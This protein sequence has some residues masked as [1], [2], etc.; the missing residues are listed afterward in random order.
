MNGNTD[1]CRL[2]SVDIRGYRVFFDF[3]IYGKTEVQLSSRVKMSSS[4]I[5]VIGRAKGKHSLETLMIY[6]ETNKGRLC[7]KA[8]TKSQ[9][10]G[11][12]YSLVIV[13]FIM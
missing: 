10:D 4:K 3:G 2:R 6:L 12:R 1:D 8:E 5:D 11:S 13:Y 7:F 9:K